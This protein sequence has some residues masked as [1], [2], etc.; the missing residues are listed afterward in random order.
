MQ[1][2]KLGWAVGLVV[3]LSGCGGGSGTTTVDG[4]ASA[5]TGGAAAAAPTDTA[6]GGQGAA[7]G[8]SS[9]DASQSAGAT[10]GG[11][12]STTPQPGGR[13][14]TLTWRVPDRNEDGTP[15]ATPPRFKIHYGRVSREYDATIELPQPGA[16]RHVFTSLEAGTWFIALTSIGAD[17]L[18]SGFSDEA[19]A[20]VN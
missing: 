8:T 17:G 7:G 5:M 15:L 9:A 14:Y 4:A 2:A 16:N 1:A 11:A 6:T 20:V 19:V 12:S 18:E 13:P 10:A 3:M